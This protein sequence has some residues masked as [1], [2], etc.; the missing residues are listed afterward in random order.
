MAGCS[1]GWLLS[2]CGGQRS[3]QRLSGWREVQGSKGCT[4]HSSLP[5]SRDLV[6][7]TLG[8]SLPSAL[9][10]HCTGVR[11][12]Q[13]CSCT[14]ALLQDRLEGREEG[15]AELWLPKPGISPVSLP[16]IQLGSTHCLQR[17]VQ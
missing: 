13:V 8:L 15:G 5:A 14:C 4:M 3:L 17:K 7:G 16:E 12:P 1:P 11:G 10:K 9:H 2:C 6:Q